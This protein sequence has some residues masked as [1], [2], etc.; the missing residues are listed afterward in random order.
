MTTFRRIEFSNNKQ[1]TDQK[2]DGSGYLWIAYAQNSDG[3]CLLNKTFSKEPK[4]IFFTLERE[5][6]KI[7]KL[8]VLGTNLWVIYQD[9]ILIGERISL[10]N[11][12]TSTTELDIPVG[13]T[14]Y[15]V[16][17][18]AKDLWVYILIPGNL[19]G[20]IAKVLRYNTS[21]VLQETIDL[22][23]SGEQINNASSFTIDANNNIWILT[24]E[25]PVK[26]VRLYD[27]GGFTWDFTS[28]E[29]V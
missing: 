4:Q 13:I 8:T 21:G 2:L 15:P 1:I 28:T 11:P 29:I 16:D 22:E 3:L 27:T 24:Y 20:T 23:K 18:I 9:D 10:N 6:D 25:S 7:I 19:S 12:I 26:V 14:E 17:I 5:V